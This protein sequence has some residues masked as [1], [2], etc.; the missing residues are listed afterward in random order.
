MFGRGVQVIRSV[1][2]RKETARL[3]PVTMSLTLRTRSRGIPRTTPSPL[4]IRH[5]STRTCGKPPSLPGKP[6]ARASSTASTASTTQRGDPLAF[7]RELASR[8]RPSHLWSRYNVLLR[9]HPLKT[10]MIT[11][12]TLFVIGDMI[13][14][15][16]IE[17]R[18]FGPGV[19]SDEKHATEAEDR[20]A[21]GHVWVRT[22][23]LAFYGVSSRRGFPGSRDSC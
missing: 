9:A 11:S 1:Q 21:E 19:W 4:R 16:I 7:L 12:G 14:Q 10:R 13:S 23:R 22:A 2:R 8:I 6:S 5:A 18:P 15:H 20:Q 17:E 3:R